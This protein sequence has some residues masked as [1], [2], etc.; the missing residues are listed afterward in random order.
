MV[1]HSDSAAVLGSVKK[2]KLNLGDLFVEMVLSMGVTVIFCCVPSHVGV[3]SNEKADVVAKSAV[4]RGG[5]YSG[6]AG[7]QGSQVLGRGKRA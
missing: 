5:R 7:P 1:V 2:C 3:E 6:P 4:R